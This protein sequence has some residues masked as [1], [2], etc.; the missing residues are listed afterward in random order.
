MFAFARIEMT[1]A[2]ANTPKLP[3]VHD[4]HIL[5]YC[6]KRCSKFASELVVLGRLSTNTCPKIC[7]QESFATSALPAKVTSEHEGRART[8]TSLT[9]EK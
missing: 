9:V 1:R 7:Q 3:P 2:L 6:F 5:A 4:L 8:R